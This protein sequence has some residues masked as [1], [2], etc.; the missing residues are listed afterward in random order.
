MKEVKSELRV[1]NPKVAEEMLK[2]NI[3]N[4]RLNI[5]H[6]RSLSKQMKDG[7]WLFD[8]APIK[9]S[10]AGGLLDGQHRL[11]AIIRSKTSQ[12]FLILTNIDSEA[13]KVM[14]TGR[15][16]TSSD[17][18]GIKGYENTGGLSA[19][20]K[21]I[22]SHKKGL[23]AIKANDTKSITNTEILEFVEKN[24]IIIDLYKE[25]APLYKTFSRILPISII[26]A[27]RFLFN[28]KNVNDAK[29]FWIG[30]CTGLNLE[31]DSPLKALRDK[32][33]Y[34][35]INRV[36]MNRKEKKAYIIKAWVAYRLKKKIKLLRYSPE[37]EKYPEII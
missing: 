13:F 34:N 27:Y 28:E 22:L 35:K 21:F 3:S 6:I 8:G 2:R 29:N 16:R 5:E 14:D 17:I 23:N 7:K 10:S 9:F 36:E 4:R 30:V 15:K 37:R 24:P 18:L 32:L 26:C 19:A 31:E 12:K 11:N 20:I 33:T 1:I 25:C